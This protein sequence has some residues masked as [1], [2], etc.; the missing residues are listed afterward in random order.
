MRTIDWPLDLTQTY[1]NV[2]MDQTPHV[3]RVDDDHQAVGQHSMVLTAD[4]AHALAA[5]HHAMGEALNFAAAKL[6]APK[7]T[8]VARP[9]QAP[10]A[11]MASQAL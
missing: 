5:A 6:T 8:G 4:E 7:T 10:Q 11:P 3:I 1:V 2:D 9:S